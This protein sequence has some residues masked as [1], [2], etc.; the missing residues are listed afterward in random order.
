M[1]KKKNDGAGHSGD[2]DSDGSTRVYLG[3]GQKSWEL[4]KACAFDHL[5]IH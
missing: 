2:G 3:S 4:D 1:L 5:F